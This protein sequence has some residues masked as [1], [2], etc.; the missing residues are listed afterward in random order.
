MNARP[1][2]ISPQCLNII[3]RKVAEKEEKNEKL[4]ISLKFDEVHIRKHIQWSNKDQKLIGFDVNNKRDETNKSDVAN[5]ALVFYVNAANDSLD[6]PIG[7]YFIN[8]M[9]GKER[10]QL[11]RKV[12]EAL[13]DCNAIVAGLIFDGFQANK[14]MCNEFGANLDVFSADFKPYITVKE[15]RICIFFD[16]CHMFKLVRNRLAAKEEL[17]DEENK[18][19]WQYFIDLVQLRKSGFSLTHK[20]TR[21]HIEF[22]QNKMRVYLAVETLSDST[23]NSM[24]LL[25]NKGLPQ[26]AGAEHTIKFIRVFN[27]LFD[28]LNT[29]HDKRE[30][31]FKKTLSMANANQVFEFIDE[32]IGYIKKLCVINDKGRKV[33]VCNSKINTGFNGCIID[34]TSLKLLFQDFV[35][36]RQMIKE[37]PTYAFQ[38]DQLEIFFGKTRASAGRN[39]NL[40]WEQ[41]CAAVRKILAFSTVMYSKKSNCKLPEVHGNCYSNIL[42]ITSQRPKIEKLSMS[43]CLEVTEEEIENLYDKLS[44]IEASEVDQLTEELTDYTVAQIANIIENRIKSTKQFDCSSCKN[45]FDENKHKVDTFNGTK[46]A[47]KPCY[48]TFCICK[49]ADRFLKEEILKGAVEFR[50]VYSEIL[51]TLNFEELFEQTDFTDHLEHK[52][53]LIRHIVNEYVKIKGTHM[54]KSLTIRE[55]QKSFR[56]KLHK[57]LHYMGQ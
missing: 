54:A 51:Q 53:Y 3:K 1:N 14:T 43:E 33:K 57:L 21:A 6:L 34:L 28:I 7:Y 11:V 31:P 15:Q 38:Q 42:S 52:I 55:H 18:I 39:D 13:I 30:S 25:M 4:I 47:V 41:F 5:Q 19:K 56:S 10:E 12:L 27:T 46:F 8:S 16:I 29:K 49:Q 22:A 40:T 35:Q 50:V 17:F 24:E 48:S 26:F 20:M 44:E 32:A 9:D 2:E 36:E 37:I 45:I 23:A